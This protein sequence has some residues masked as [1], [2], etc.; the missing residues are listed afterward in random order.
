M[1]IKLP[2]HTR[3]ICLLLGLLLCLLTV[4]CSRKTGGPAGSAPQTAQPKQIETVTIGGQTMPVDTTAL[5][6]ALAEGETALLDRLPALRT[7]DLSGSAD[8]AEVAAWAKA[9]PQVEVRYSVTLPDGSILSSDT[10]T[11]DLSGYSGEQLQNAAGA[12]RLL[13]ELSRIEL[14]SE[15]PDL[16]WE[17]I[18]AFRA[19]LPET[20][21]SYAFDLYGTSCNLEDTTINLYHVPID[22]DDGAL[23][24]R[25]MDLMPQLVSADLDSCS[26]PMWRCE[27]INLAH[28]DVKVIFRVW[29]G[30]NYSVRTD[31]EMILA[32]MPSRGGEITPE[33]S[34]GLSYCHDVKYLDVG[35]NLQL[36]DISFVKEMPKLEVGI[37][38]MCNWSD[39]TP[40]SY[41]PELEYIEM[42]TTLCTDLRPLSGLTKLR[43]LNIC[44]IGADQFGGTPVEL[45]DISPL[46]SLTGL[47][48]LWVGGLNPVPHEQIEE[49]QRRAPQCEINASVA[50]PHGGNWRCTELADFIYTYV[51]TFHPRYEKLREQF[52]NYEYASYCFSWNDPLY[53]ED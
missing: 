47:E 43:H 13:P 14:G 21:F 5:T 42:Q 30:T 1:D 46:Y 11:V 10:D 2:R 8:P 26:L 9:H 24:E 48:R 6:A 35:H 40:L 15:R 37:F 38:A 44:S 45:T 4:G 16:S 19:A 50:D 23:L 28:P 22:S 18:A 33:N 32:S 34:E 31:V 52:G 29:F 41:C 7:A 53:Y 49:M 36:T 27:E 51:D 12:L 39:A 17:D 3:L 25:V 20:T